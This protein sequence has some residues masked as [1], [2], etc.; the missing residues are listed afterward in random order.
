MDVRTLAVIAA[1]L[2]TLVV[3]AQLGYTTVGQ[4]VG[5]RWS[6]PTTAV[7]VS[8]EDAG[9][10]E[11]AAA[12]DAGGG[13]VAWIVR[14]G[15]RYR[16]SF[17]RVTV[18]AG[19]VS[20]GEPRTVATVD[21]ELQG[22]DAAVAGDDVALAWERARANDIV[23]Y[24]RGPAEPRVVSDDPLRVAEP[25]VVLVG[26][27][28][29]LAWQ[30]WADPGFAIELAGVT[31]QGVSY[32][33]VD[34]AT[35]GRGSPALD[36]TRDGFAVTW[37]DAENRTATTAFGAIDSGTVTLAPSQRLGQARP[38]GDFGGGTG[39]I[40]IDAGADGDVVRG[41]WLDL[42]TVTT[43]QTSRT[44][45]ASEPVSLG[46]G[47]RPRVAVGE[48]RW[49]A[50]W[51]VSSRGADTDLAYVVG[52]DRAAG[53]TLSRFESSANHPSPFFGP[54]PAA[55]W[56]ERGAE[57]RVLVSGYRDSPERRYLTRLQTEPG[58]LVF[59]GLAAAA[60]GVVTLPIMPWIF[61]SALVAF[62]VTNRFI[63]TRLI[64]TLARLSGLLGRSGDQSVAR[65]RLEAVPPI[66]WAGVFAVGEV[67]VLVTLLP[68]VG[69]T[70]AL[71]FA[72]PVVLSVA[73]GIGTVVVHLVA[74]QRSP[75]RLVAVFAFFQTAALW[76]T[77]LPDVL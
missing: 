23:L 21:R 55:A 38:A 46:S 44:G 5:E 67:A 3:G 9:V 63:R 71:S 13:V 60:L 64:R 36:A 6:D 26:D 73:A 72:G 1:V 74:P 53:G 17:V 45:S 65:A 61:V 50:A 77:A 15:D 51:V 29:V 12:G 52:G 57:G 54:D 75:W 62:Y 70:V 7:A 19:D 69:A 58:R 59:I 49:L 32:R 8:S 56:A 35:G 31:D 43:A 4:P 30:Q 10:V 18:V 24:R 22:L 20:L 33:S 66:A 47:E 76:A 2:L 39:P 27:G 68:S 11:I 42:A 25:S 41:I 37:F 40:S 16:I 34:V 14:A 28:A 48:G